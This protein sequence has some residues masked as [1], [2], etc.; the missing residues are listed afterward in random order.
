MIRLQVQLLVAADGDYKLME[1][2]LNYK[3]AAVQLPEVRRV[4]QKLEPNPYDTAEVLLSQ[5]DQFVVVNTTSTDKD[6]AVSGVVGLDVV[7]EVITGQGLD[8][9]LGSQD[10][11]TEGFT[12]E[13]CNDW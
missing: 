11:A 6:H 9:L 4:R 12:Y 10:G 1:I 2:N 13:I 7:G 5:L 3:P 8:V